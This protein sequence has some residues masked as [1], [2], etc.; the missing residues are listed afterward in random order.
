[1]EALTDSGRQIVFADASVYAEPGG[2]RDSRPLPIGGTRFSEST[3]GRGPEFP[4]GRLRRG[5]F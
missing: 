3:A 2:K 4:A 5:A 1:M